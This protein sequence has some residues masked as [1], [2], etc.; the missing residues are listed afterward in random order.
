M[1]KKFNVFLFV[2]WESDFS[3]V[4]TVRWITIFAKSKDDVRTPMKHRGFFVSKATVH[5]CRNF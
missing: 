5:E 2:H 3:D 1:M 4:P